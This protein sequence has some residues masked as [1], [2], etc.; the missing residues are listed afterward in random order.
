M[1]APGPVD[2]DDFVAPRDGGVPSSAPPKVRSLGRLPELDGLRAIALT[3][4]VLYHLFGHGRVSGGVDVFLFVSG[5]VL[6]LSLHRDVQR[7]SQATVLS[8]WSRTFARLAPPAALVLV[9]VIVMSFTILPPWQR[10][11][12]LGEVIASALYVENWQLIASQLSYGAAGPGTSP[13]QHFWSL[14][15]Q[16]QLIIVLPLVVALVFAARRL[17]RRPAVVLSWLALL[18]TTASFVYATL[19]QPRDPAVAYFDTVARFWELGA[20][21][22]VAR[23]L[24]TG[25]TLP[26][27]LSALLGWFGLTAVVASGFIVDGSLVYPGP[28]ALLP[29]TGAAL[30]V[31]SI[32]GEGHGPGVLLRSPAFGAFSRIS[33]ALYLWHWPVLILFLTLF[34]R[35]GDVVGWRGATAVLLISIVLSIATRALVERP[36]ERRLRR[37]SVAAKAG[38]AVGSIALVV[39]LA[40]GGMV[41]PAAVAASTASDSG[42]GTSDC[43][44]DASSA[45]ASC[46]E[47]EASCLGAAALDPL[48][49]ECA[50]PADAEAPLLPDYASL[51][52]DDD[53]RAEC[54]GTDKAAPNAVCS[55]GPARGYTRHLLAVGDSHNNVYVGVYEKIAL[56]N[57]WRIDV[58]GRP[59]C[60][61][62]VATREQRNTEL[63]E[64]CAAWNDFI[65]EYVATTDLDGVITTNSSRAEYVVPD[66][67]PLAEVR[68]AGFVEAWSSRS[69][70][71]V[72]VFAVRDYPV[73]PPSSLACVL[74]RARVADGECAIPR[75]EALLEDGLAEAVSRDPNA[76]LIDLSDYICA[77][78]RCDL[79]VGGVIVS[80]DG[81][82]LTATYARTLKPYFERALL[83]VLP[84]P[85]D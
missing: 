83:E 9:A 55:L 25:L 39:A 54:W 42:A 85:A 23:V 38:T 84:Q 8:R 24:L 73:F 13:V 11:Q 44:V 26:R 67:Q 79:V 76:H 2:L 51:R 69:D 30:V 28:V 20:G 18:A 46:A 75:D 53:N 33:Y 37:S 3:L 32:R 56:D 64:G 21:V 31:L 16:G 74:D 80:R 4:V 14:S 17:V 63:T 70:P 71:A 35:T 58:A 15:I 40:I 22:L 59:G 78:D 43:E 27:R 82:H 52:E 34:P 45:A 47:S 72:P 7:G 5:V 66:G 41:V 62:T 65:D 19:L 48:R 36:L 81:S 6:A 29:V 60:H 77:A 1:S 57:G 10:D 49:P 68:T 50:G 61:W 12:T